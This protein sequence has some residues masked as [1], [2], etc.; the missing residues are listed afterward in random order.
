MMGGDR[1]PPSF[2][3]VVNW[4]FRLMLD[5]TAFSCRNVR[6]GVC[7]EI[8][9]CCTLTHVIHLPQPVVIR[10][11]W[12]QWLTLF[13]RFLDSVHGR[14]SMDVHGRFWTVVDA[15]GRPWM[16]VH[17][18]PF[19]STAARLA[20]NAVHHR[21][22]PPS[23]VLHR[24]PPSIFV[25]DC[26][27]P[28]TAIYG[29]LLPSITVHQRPFSSNAG[30]YCPSSSSAL[31]NRSLPS[32]SVYLAVTIFCRPSPS[33]TVLSRPLS[34]M[35]VHNSPSSFTTVHFRPLPINTVHHRPSPSITIHN[36]SIT[37]HHRP[38]S[39]T[40]VQPTLSTIVYY[41]TS[42]STLPFIL[43]QHRPIPCIAVHHRP[44]SSTT[45][46]CHQ[47]S[48]IHHHPWRKSHTSH[49]HST[50]STA[51]QVRSGTT[52]HRGP[53]IT[54]YCRKKRRPPPITSSLPRNTFQHC[55]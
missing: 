27:S 29:R 3:D 43:D 10:K 21:P 22:L 13:S 37:V 54:V 25:Q 28:L 20:S 49:E 24:L 40:A 26:S 39:P 34:S 12:Y 32:I 9:G 16:C 15:H 53:S 8:L 30:N 33:N 14:P 51:V 17:H 1:K 23:T 44:S 38:L 6:L 35:T 36:S 55:P 18:L 7:C 41:R 31:H 11:A 45:L 19:P 46:Y 52:V 48:S 42:K 47:P 4:W 50:A 5:N 2:S